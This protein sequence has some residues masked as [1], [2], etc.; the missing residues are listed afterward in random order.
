[1]GSGKSTV[2]PP[3][4]RRL[5]YDF[6]D[7]DDEIERLA[8]RSIAKMFDDEGEAAFRRLETSALRGTAATKDV[9]VALGGGVMTR[10][11]NRSFLAESGVTIY[12]QVPAGVLVE[13]L[14][15]IA[16]GRPLLLDARGFVLGEEA[17]RDRIETML[18]ERES[19]YRRADYVVSAAGSD[20]DETVDRIERLL[21]G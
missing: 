12:L 1:M 6:I 8:S 19:A 11:I 16:S 21:R 4:A 20:V 10:A 18:V 3:L 2:G 17:M 9:V 15:P 7:L 5:G 13:R 14:R